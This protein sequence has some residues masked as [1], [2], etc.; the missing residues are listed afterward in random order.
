MLVM[1]L[2]VA[3]SSCQQKAKQ[4]TNERAAGAQ[5]DTVVVKT[6]LAS[7]RDMACGM[8]VKDDVKDT[9]HYEGKVYGFCSPSCKQDFLADP[10]SFLKQ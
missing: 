10:K 3:I 8:G 1:I 7:N 4:N 2:V 9:A 5:K 6:V